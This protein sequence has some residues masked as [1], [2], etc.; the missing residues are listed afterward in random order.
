MFLR[1]VTL[2]GR[3]EEEICLF[4]VIFRCLQETLPHYLVT[5]MPPLKC[6]TSDGSNSV[7]NISFFGCILGCCKHNHL[8]KGLFLF[9]KRNL[10]VFEEKKSLLGEV[11]KGSHNLF[12]L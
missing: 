10:H 7:T 1:R 6:L 9:K 5:P 12:N 2:S 3:Q 8:S 11:K 4:S